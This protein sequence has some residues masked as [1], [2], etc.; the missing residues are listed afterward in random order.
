MFTRRLFYSLRKNLSQV[1]LFTENFWKF[2]MK[3]YFALVSILLFSMPSVANDV[4]KI[5]L[6]KK[7]HE[8]ITLRDYI[9]GDDEGVAAYADNDL[10]RWIRLGN[11]KGSN[12]YDNGCFC[13]DDPDVRYDSQDPSYLIFNYGI[14]PKGYVNVEVKAVRE[15]SEQ[16]IPHQRNRQYKLSG[17]PA[18]YKVSDVLIQEENGNWSSWKQGFKDCYAGRAK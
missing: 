1:T 14:S 11:A 8:P 3:Q 5:K 6:V 10:K 4:E 2:V 15:S 12:C 7:I 13:Y 9:L 16:Y 17:S 18:N